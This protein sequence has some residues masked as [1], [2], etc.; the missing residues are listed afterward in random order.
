MRNVYA[1][2]YIYRGRHSSGIT[3]FRKAQ[4]QS[5]KR[6]TTNTNDYDYYYYYYY[7]YYY[8]YY[9]YYYYYY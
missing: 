4:I 7:C 3:S 6:N 5:T 8:Y 9:H 2:M 1:R